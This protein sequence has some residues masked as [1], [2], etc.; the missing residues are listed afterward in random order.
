M[1]VRSLGKK[2]LSRRQFLR[3]SAAGATL[4][5]ALPPLELFSPSRARAEGE[6][7]PFFGL[8]FWANGLPWH[9]A[10]G[11]EQGAVGNGDLWT[12]ATMGP[13]YAATPL[14][15]PLARH[16]VS[17]I[18]GLEP[19][20]VIPNSPPGQ[21]DGHMRGFMVSL[22]GDRPRSEGFNHSSHTLTARRPSLDQVV[23]THPDFY[24]RAPRFRSIEV[25]V[26][27]ARFHR[28]G[29]WDAISYSGPNATNAPIMAPSL[30]YDRLFA[31]PQDDQSGRRRVQLLDA[32]LE[33]ARTLRRQLG[34]ED[35][36]RLEAHI[37]HLDT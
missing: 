10:H 1:S 32:V 36:R 34:V 13:S 4:S 9:S 27:E 16:Q 30:L 5:L 14:L 18:S 25:G 11:G 26:S 6:V 22:T 24:R 23:A 3:G 7:E 8:F 17:V 19:H 33:D 28:Y 2:Q 20:T 12:P 37:E 15:A 21:G 29:H 35:R 31:A